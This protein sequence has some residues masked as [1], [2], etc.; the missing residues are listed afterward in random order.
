[1]LFHMQKIIFSILTIT[2]F[3]ILTSAFSYS[4]EGYIEEK[5]QLIP[6]S[7]KAVIAQCTDG[8]T[9]YTYEN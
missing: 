2:V 8:S 6:G 9:A 3:I 4:Q 5:P 7:D 1:M